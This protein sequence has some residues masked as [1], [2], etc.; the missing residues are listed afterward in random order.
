MYTNV[1]IVVI[2]QLLTVVNPSVN[3]HHYGSLIPGI[4]INI[5]GFLS[6][7]RKYDIE[8]P[9]EKE[10]RVA[11]GKDCLSG[12]QFF[13]QEQLIGKQNHLGSRHN[14]ICKAAVCIPRKL[15]PD[16]FFNVFKE[17]EHESI[18]VLME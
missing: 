11:L 10:L 7:C 12:K 2:T 9:Q 5:K 16:D 14:Q 1:F 18:S 17:G 13:L 4:A 3:Y 15:F 6:L 8:H